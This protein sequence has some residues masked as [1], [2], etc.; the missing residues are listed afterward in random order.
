LLIKKLYTNILRCFHNK[1][2]IP[3]RLIKGSR[4]TYDV[5]KFKDNQRLYRSCRLEDFGEDGKIRLE[6]IR[7]PDLSCNWSMFSEPQDVWYR[8]NGSIN[9]GCYS[10]SIKASRFKNLATPVHDPLDDNF[11]HTELRAVKQEATED[12]K[13]TPLKGHKMSKA[14]RAEYRA[15]IRGNMRIDLVARKNKYLN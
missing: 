12:E 1:K 4:E 6:T 5:N 3:I 15:N 7:F 13:S 11:S 10:F 2:Q 8:E 14:K 9:D